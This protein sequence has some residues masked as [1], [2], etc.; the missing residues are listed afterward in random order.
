MVRLVAR[1]PPTPTTR[2]TAL[3]SAS[4]DAVGKH[5]VGGRVDPGDEH[6]GLPERVGEVERTVEQVEISLEG[7]GEV[8][9]EGRQ[10]DA[11]CRL[12]LRASMR[13]RWSRTTVLPVPAPPDSRNGPL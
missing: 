7:V 9:G 12:P 13:A 2:S 8:P 5:V 1:F 11:G 10:Y 4:G 6:A 3:L